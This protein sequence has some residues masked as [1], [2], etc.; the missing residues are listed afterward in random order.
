MEQHRHHGHQRLASAEVANLLES[1]AYFA[2]TR[3]TAGSA[4]GSGPRDAAGA[5]L[6]QTLPAVSASVLPM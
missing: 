3:M 5:D 1:I 6:L 4:P 2:S